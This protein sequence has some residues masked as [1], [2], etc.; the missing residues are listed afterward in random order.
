MEGMDLFGIEIV[1]TGAYCPSLSVTNDDLAKVV[2]TSDE[3]IFSRTG[4]RSRRIA[5]GEAT[6]EMG[7]AAAE[8]A[9]RSAGIN[10]SEVGLIIDTTITSD[11][12]T[13]SM[14]CV[15]QSR[16]GAGNAAAFDLGAACSGFVYGLDAA[17]RYLQTDP[18]LKYVLVVSNEKLSNIT[19]YSD[20]SSCILFGDGAAAAVVTRSEKLY[21]SYI[22]AN[23]NGAKFLYAKNHKV[24]HPFRT[25]ETDSIETGEFANGS[26]FLFQDGKEVYKFATKALPSAAKKAAEKIN[27][28]INNIDWFIPHQANIRIIE[29]AAK[30]LGVPMDKFVVNIKEHGNTSS[31]SI[32][33]ALHEAI[34][35]GQVK[36]GD[37]LCLVGFGAGLTLGAIITEY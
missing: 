20:R 6:W 16:I 28:D 25:A 14:A 15:I 37:K 5:N 17:K 31:A 4:I 11:F 29:A 36:R 3:W 24:L 34:T 13:P 18:E 1:G 23:G 35:S 19:D 21:S 8:E 26:V 10:G 30:N 7:A 33:I 32:P 2:D 27:M 9:L 22:G 12:S